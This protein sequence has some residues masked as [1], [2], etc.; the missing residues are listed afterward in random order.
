MRSFR[1]PAVLTAGALATL[2]LLSGCGGADSSPEPDS[3]HASPATE[4]AALG[5]L[6]GR[7]GAVDAANRA[8]AASGRSSP[9]VSPDAMRDRMPERAAGLLRSDLRVEPGGGGIPGATTVR[10]TY[11]A[12]ARRVEISIVDMGSVPGLAGSVVPWLGAE[13]D[14]RTAGGFERTVQIQGLQGFEAERTGGGAARSEV[15]V[16]AGGVLVRLEG[17][18]V[19]VE[20]LRESLR[21]MDPGGIGR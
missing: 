12:G 10:S 7:M 14:R 15:A 8:A 3:P 9:A 4:A 1:S 11:G 18:G 20:A 6:P 19:G 21:Q 16:M 17:W 5:T 2:L 13:F